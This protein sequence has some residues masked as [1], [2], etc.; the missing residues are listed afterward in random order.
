[1]WK[2]ARSYALRG[3]PSLI[4]IG[5]ETG[6]IG[7]AGTYFDVRLSPDETKL[8]FASGATSDI[9]VDELA[10]GVRMCLTIDPG[11]DH[12]HPVWS[13][14]GSRI[15]FGAFQGKVR[16]GIYQKP[17]NG[18]GGEELLQSAETSDPQLWP[19]SCSRDGRFILYLRIDF[20]DL[21]PGIWILPLAGEGKPR[22]L[23]KAPVKASDGQFSPDDRWVAYASRESGREEVYVVPFEAANVLKSGTESVTSPEGKWQISPGGG[24]S[25]RWRRDGKEIFYLD[26]GNEIMAAEVEVRGNSLEVRK[27]LP[28]FR[29]AVAGFFSPYDVTPDGKRF[30]INTT[31]DST[32]KSLTL[33]VNWTALLDNKR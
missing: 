17:S 26:P 7:E 2:V 32:N 28:L 20:S 14:D 21:N 19:S 13:P 10:R 3:S 12:G 31:T 15:L 8:A 30:V 5:K 25:P 24:R 9:W 11:S 33:V 29:A 27:A 22:L 4:G 16:S 1:M 6:V 23:V 18:A